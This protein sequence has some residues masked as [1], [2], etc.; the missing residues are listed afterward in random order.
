MPSGT[1]AVPAG[2]VSVAVAGGFVATY[3]IT[4]EPSWNTTTW[5]TNKTAAGFTVNFNVAAPV[6]G[7]TIDWTAILTA[8]AVVGS[9]A[10]T[11][12]DYRTALREL[13]HD[14]N[15]DYWSLAD[16]DIYLNRALQRRDLDTGGNRQLVTFTLTVGL[17]NYTLT[18]IGL[19]NVFDIVGIN[20]IFVSNRVILNNV[21]FRRLNRLYR[22]WTPYQAV[23]EG[24][25]RYGPNTIYF[26]P[27]PS[28]A[29]T[30]EWDCC[31]YSLPNTLVNPGDPDPL[32]YPYTEPVPYYAAH[33]AKINERQY[34][35]SEGFLEAYRERALLATNQ[36]TGMV[37]SFYGQALMGR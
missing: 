13:L 31:V 16:K 35:E 2:S 28:F 14:P 20:L 10:V 26:G 12:A 6:G 33:L 17:D 7:G 11:L 36:R 24:W 3:Q 30:T 1:V 22:P 5:I 25:A 27:A 18:A 21:G 19:P 15:D 8:A 4:V 32:P 23:C 29:Y 9:T 37:P 34:D